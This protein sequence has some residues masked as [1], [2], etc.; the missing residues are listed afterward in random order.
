MAVA[1][2][3]CPSCGASIEFGVGSSIAKVCEYCRSTVVRS[4][5][6]LENL[7]RCAELVNTPSLIEVGDTGTL[8]GRPFR[9]MGRVQLNHGRGPWDEYYVSFDYGRSWGWLAYAQGQWYATSQVSGLAV[10]GYQEL[11]PELDVPLGQQWFRV[12]EVKSGTIVSAEGELPEAFPAGFTRYYA[13]CY[14][15]GGGFATLDYG[16]GTKPYTV[17]IGYVF[18]ESQLKVEQQGPR[19]IHKVK[20]ASIKCANCGGDVP[21]LSG[22]RATRV[23]CPYCGA[24]NDIALQQVVAQQERLMQ[25]PLIPIGARGVFDGVEYIT[26][27]S[28]RRGAMFGDD[29]DLEH[30]SWE[31]FLLWSEGI[32]YRWLV[33]DETSWMWVMPVNVAELDLSQAH[34]AVSWGGRSFAKRNAQ[35]ATVEYVLGEVYWKVELGDKVDVADYVNG[36]DVL[37]RESSDGEVIWS[38]STQVPWPVLAQAFNLPLDSPAGKFDASSS[39]S[40]SDSSSGGGVWGTI[41]LVVVLIACGACVGFLQDSDGGGGGVVGGSGVFTGGK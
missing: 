8:G 20:A 9:V 21:K 32:G 1:Q 38:Y 24:V 12:A 29:D 14:A 31:E 26:I 19:S 5:R 7:G 2:G 4:D 18:S 25:Q 39:S 28:I 3:T 13:D 11:R 22:E 17:F 41:A 36:T 6:G 33:K 34:A 30:F 35:D 37:S 10:P 23:G 15:A 40:S 16:D 27:A